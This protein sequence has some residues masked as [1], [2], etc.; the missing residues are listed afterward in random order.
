MQSHAFSNDFQNYDIFPWFP[1]FRYSP[2]I[3]FLHVKVS[4][5]FDITS[6]LPVIFPHRHPCSWP[7]NK[8]WRRLEGQHNLE[9]ILQVRSKIPICVLSSRS[10]RAGAMQGRS[11]TRTWNYL[12]KSL[13]INENPALELRSASTELTSNYGAGQKK[14]TTN[15]CKQAS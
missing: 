7:Q 14:Q 10:H 5:L 1:K 11:R 9:L 2:L 15:I 6:Q 8:P 3:F 13:N 12:W 4:A